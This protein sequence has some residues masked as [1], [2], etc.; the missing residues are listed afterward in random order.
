MFIHHVIPEIDLFYL[1]PCTKN[2]SIMFI[3]EY[4]SICRDGTGKT[5]YDYQSTVLSV[6]LYTF[7]AVAIF[8]PYQSFSSVFISNKIVSVARDHCWTT[9]LSVTINRT[10]FFSQASTIMAEAFTM[11]QA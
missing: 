1:L 4:G 2:L 11:I 8:E 7:Y 3:M 5:A 9:T 6:I 10:S